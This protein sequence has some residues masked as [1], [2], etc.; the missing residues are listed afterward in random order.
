M[1]VKDYNITKG[2]KRTTA[3]RNKTGGTNYN[4]EEVSLSFTLENPTNKEI[5]EI[6]VRVYNDA[7]R[8]LGR[9]ITDDWS[10]T[11]AQKQQ[12]LFKKDA[13]ELAEG[14]G[15]VVKKK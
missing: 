13:E 7:H 9:D 8:E 11:D 10:K 14:I 4:S 3:S 2:L 1:S 15:K 5:E 6:N 12:E